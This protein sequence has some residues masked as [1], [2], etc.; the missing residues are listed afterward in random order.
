MAIGGLVGAGYGFTDNNKAVFT[1]CSFTGSILSNFVSAESTTTV[2]TE[3][4]K[5]NNPN[6]R[7]MGWLD[8][9]PWKTNEGCLTIT[10]E[11]Q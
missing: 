1:D 11:V 5:A 3:T 9:S 7:Y 2:H 10:P 4:V 8:G 6:W